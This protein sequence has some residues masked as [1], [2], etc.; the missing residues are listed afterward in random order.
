[1]ATEKQEDNANMA[2]D[3]ADESYYA[4]FWRRLIASAIDWTLVGFVLFVPGSIYMVI[5]A[6]IA[7]QRA[8][9]HQSFPLG[10]LLIA[11]FWPFLAL[12]ILGYFT[13]STMHGRTLG[14][15]MVGI[16]AL[17]A[18]TGKPPSF[19]RSVVRS[20]LGLALLSFASLLLNVFFADPP[21]DGYSTMETLIMALVTG[22][23]FI[24]YLRMIWDSRRQT[25]HDKLT[26]VVVV[27]RGSAS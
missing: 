18:K 2:Q 24:G 16:R 15:R 4:S 25:L 12:F 19:K 5:V 9:A 27:R 6:A 10:S 22:I 3:E 1:M 11:L 26:G 17:H 7:L 21:S 23:G 13:F 20:F 8:M 14:M